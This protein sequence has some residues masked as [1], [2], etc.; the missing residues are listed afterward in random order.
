MRNAYCS[1]RIFNGWRQSMSTPFTLK[2]MAQY[3]LTSALRKGVEQVRVTAMQDVSDSFTVRNDKLEKLYQA[4]ES[5]L[6]IHLFADGRYGTCSTNRPEEKEIDRLLDTAIASTRLLAADP[7]RVLPPAEKCYNGLIRSGGGLPSDPLSVEAKKKTAFECA[8]GV[9][10]TDPSL[11][12]VT[13]DYSDSRSCLYIIDSQDLYC[14]SSDTY[15][16]LSAECAVNGPHNTRPSDWYVKGGITPDAIGIGESAPDNCARLALE[17]ALA[18]RAPGKIPSGYYNMVVENRA[19][20]TLLA[21]VIQA[22]SGS[23]LQQGSSFL[24][25]MLGKQIAASHFTLKDE[26]HLPNEPGRR[27]FD[28]EGLA[29]KP[30]TIIENGILNL[31]FLSTYFAGKMQMTP[32]IEG[33]SV[34][35]LEGCEKDLHSLFQKAGKG[36]LVTGFNGGNC[37]GTTGDFSYGI[38]GF[39]FENGDIL[40][41]LNEMIISGNMKDLWLRFLS[42]ADD[43]LHYSAW[44]IPS[45]LFE[46][47][48][49]A[50]L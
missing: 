15:Y 40:R 3:A 2:D 19:A 30:R 45:L 17:R 14:F 47:I 49:F 22:M 42:A 8:A 31:Y 9:W 24:L 34:L 28:S 37:N 11:V 13:A 7:Y 33:P 1:C 18:K 36:V 6:F 21:P 43:A 5:S 35:Q 23:A 4:G 44:Q 10:G 46:N 48:A 12:H 16:S 38:E 41:P 32:T 50:G 20:S 29:T 39:L 25:N 27:Y 26:P